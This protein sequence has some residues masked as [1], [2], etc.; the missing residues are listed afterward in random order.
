[1]PA[2]LGRQATSGLPSISHSKSV[3]SISPSFNS[4]TDIILQT[5]F[6]YQ[7]R[8]Q[9]LALIPFIRRI[10]NMISSVITSVL[11]LVSTAITSV[12]AAPPQAVLA[13]SDI[14]LASINPACSLFDAYDVPPP[15]DTVGTHVGPVVMNTIGE[16]GVGGSFPRAYLCFNETKKTIYDARGLNCFSKGTNAKL[17]C[18]RG[19]TGDNVF[20]LRTA[21]RLGQD[22]PPTVLWQDDTQFFFLCP[23]LD[24][25]VTP[26]PLH[27]YQRKI[28][29]GQTPDG[30]KVVRLHKRLSYRDS[31]PAPVSEVPLLSRNPSIGRR[32]LDDRM[33][34]LKN[35]PT[36][37][38]SLGP[39]V[40]P[41]TPRGYTHIDADVDIGN[42]RLDH[43]VN[44]SLAIEFEFDI[45][46]SFPR[47]KKD[48][49]ERCGLLLNL[50]DCRKVPDSAF[51]M[52]ILP[53]MDI[54]KFGVELELVKDSHPSTSWTG[55]VF[56][57]IKPDTC[58][59]LAH[60]K[61]D[62]EARQMTW[63]LRAKGGWGYQQP[64]DT[65][66]AQGSGPTRF[67]QME[68]G[69]VKEAGLFLAACDPPAKA[70][71]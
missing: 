70:S 50:P 58:M 45:P 59:L 19:L 51:C 28:P 55:S 7:H 34:D 47:D 56:N 39:V 41:S 61:C 36:C 52:H 31:R 44:A 23:A 71:H 20:D 26:K 62:T 4:S 13:A 49:G 37:H 5:P 17:Q 60:F 10:V 40:K 63:I 15:F 65:V 8:R 14:N 27:I 67:V 69:K 24:S 18:Y 1:M 53:G 16:I 68:E 46:A 42:D 22:H 38:L 21:T 25:P 43:I 54:D 11:L 30:C 12:I 32:S 6:I 48:D 29:A 64:M 57:R 66:G 3:L 35:F 9:L 33:D 2:W